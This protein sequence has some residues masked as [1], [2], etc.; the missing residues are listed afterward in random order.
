VLS[1]FSQGGAKRLNI[2]VTPQ[3]PAIGLLGVAGEAKAALGVTGTDNT[4]LH[5]FGA[6]EHGGVQL[7]SG[8]DRAVLRVFDAADKPRAVLGLL[9]KESTPG[10]ILND[11]GG[12]SRVTL[13]LSPRGPALEFLGGDKGV[14][15]RAP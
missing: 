14:L 12:V 10:L 11:V 4:Y 15:W 6:R 3:G 13:L 5:L 9:E 8:S 2:S 7:S 1:M